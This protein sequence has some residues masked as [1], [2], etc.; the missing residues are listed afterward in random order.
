MG[1]LKSNIQNSL[2]ND[3]NEDKTHFIN[4]VQYDSNKLYHDN[5]S[6]KYNESLQDN[7]SNE[8]CTL[9]SYI[10]DFNSMAPNHLFDNIFNDEDNISP[11]NNE[12]INQQ[13]LE[14]PIIKN[15]ITD[16]NT[17]TSLPILN[18]SSTTSSTSSPLFINNIIQ[19]N[20]KSNM[21]SILANDFHYNFNV[22]E[23]WP[24]T[25]DPSPEYSKVPHNFNSTPDLNHTNNIYVC[26]ER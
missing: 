20:S 22:I 13:P 26:T 12:I 23:N 15:I 18:N 9:K 3:Y 25:P 14:F 5:T 19:N 16:M 7:I 10:G 1:K 21:N 11:F 24:P 6:N 2:N 8:N 4:L 17:S